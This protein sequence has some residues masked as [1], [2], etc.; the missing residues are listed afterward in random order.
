M[1]KKSI[2]EKVWLIPDSYLPSRSNGEMESH[3]S[4]CVL[5]VS[6]R[7]AKLKF[8]FYFEDR[9]PITG[10]EAVCPA[11]RTL[12]IRI[13]QLKSRKG[14]TIP[15]AK[16]MAYVVESNVNI[17]VQHTRVD[18]SQ[19]PLALMTTMGFPMK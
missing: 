9:A 1:S 17:V 13:N 2:G 15:L 10:C 7:P 14:E 18:S 8:T 3:E 19:S 5:N 12:H 11:E 6:R 16:S 4:A